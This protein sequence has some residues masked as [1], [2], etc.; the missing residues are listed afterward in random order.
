MMTQFVSHPIH[1]S[2]LFCTKNGMEYAETSTKTHVGTHPACYFP[3][4]PHCTAAEGPVSYTHLD[5]Y[6]R[7]LFN[8]GAAA[9]FLPLRKGLALAAIASVALALQLAWSYLT[10]D[11]ISRPLIEIPMF[12]ISYLA[13]A[14]LTSLLGQQLR[15][16]AALAE[17]RGS[18][19]ANLAEVNELIIRRMRTGVLL[20]DGDGE[21]RLA[22]EARCV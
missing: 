5:V 11:A 6:K 15:A 22:N 12:A 2:T 8:I 9:L 17:Q 19:A 16:T 13:I 21:I 14:T 10:Q 1:H 20:V 7:Q 18:Q 3:H 4:V